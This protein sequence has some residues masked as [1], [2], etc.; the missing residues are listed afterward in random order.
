MRDADEAAEQA[1]AVDAAGE[2]ADPPPAGG[3]A[4][5]PVAPA[6][7]VEVGRDQ[8]V[9]DFA[10][11]V[12]VRLGDEAAEALVGRQVADRRRLQPAERDVGAIEVHRDDRSRVR[13]EVGQGVAPAAGNADDA[14]VA[15]DR[16]AFHVHHRVFPYLGIDQPLERE[17]ESPVEQLLPGRA[18]LRTTASSMM[19]LA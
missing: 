19:R 11:L 13:H 5:F 12:V 14:A 2:V 8:A 9:V 10:V 7:R 1:L 4:A 3:I 18:A 15:L 17:G 16:Q 6:F